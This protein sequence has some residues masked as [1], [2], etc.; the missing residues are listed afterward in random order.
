[1]IERYPRVLTVVTWKWHRPGYRSAFTGE[2]VN[3]LA[4]M[5]AKHYPYPHKVI[6]VTNEPT[7]IDS[8]ITVIPDDKDFEDVPSPHG[9][10]NPTCYRRLRGWHPNAA[11]W[12]GER[13]VSIDLDTVIT[14]D[15]SSIWNRP[16][17]VVLYSDPLY[18][19]RQ[20]CGAMVLMTAGAHPEVWNDFD[21]ATSPRLAMAAG[22]RGSDQAWISYKLPRQ[23][24]WGREDGVYSYRRD[25][26]ATGRLPSDA[27]IV[28]FHGRTDPWS[29]EAQKLW[30]V[31]RH[32]DGRPT[33][34]GASAETYIDLGSDIE[35]RIKLVS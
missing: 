14:A 32:Y 6:C 2:H 8:A 28:M 17:P 9:G 27:K 26:E 1:M 33:A 25:I 22:K 18:P 19:A 30:W 21:P 29:P 16:E 15:V 23:A 13:F 12:F 7:G 35:N 5:V 10:M 24:T 34:D 31:R 4:A 20:Y 11:Q 3:K